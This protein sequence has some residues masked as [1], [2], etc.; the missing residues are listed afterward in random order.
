MSR[1]TIRTPEI[2]LKLEQAYSLGSTHATACY[3]AGISETTLYR[4]FDE[5]SELREVMKGHREKPVLK[6]LQTV[7]NDL[8]SPQTAKW[9]LERKH[10]DFK[11]ENKTKI[12][13]DDGKGGEAPINAQPDIDLSKLSLSALNE[14][15]QL[16]ADTNKGG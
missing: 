8:D 5:D 6:A 3:Y 9:L 2:E 10:P 1:P 13:T 14:L 12:V 7:A 15:E 4:W 16:H 11:A